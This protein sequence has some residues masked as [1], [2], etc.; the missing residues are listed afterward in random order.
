MPGLGSAPLLLLVCDALKV[1]EERTNDEVG[2][3][4]NKDDAGLCKDDREVVCTA[5]ALVKDDDAGDVS[6]NTSTTD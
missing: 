4:A 6:A 2:E 5:V 3:G 1:G